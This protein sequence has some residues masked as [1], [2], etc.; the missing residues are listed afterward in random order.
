MKKILTLSCFLSVLASIS[1]FSCKSKKPASD[2]KTST[3]TTTTVTASAPTYT[4]EIKNII[5]QAC[6]PCHISAQEGPGPYMPAHNPALDGY[7]KV[8][9]AATH[10]NFLGAINHQEG[11]A[12]MPMN[13]DK[14]N[15]VVIQKITAWI[16]NGMPE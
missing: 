11:F 9:A 2:A 16:Q 14:L 6:L 5:D 15:D 1:I 3:V 8:K 12:A 13:R 4:S 10:T 7:Q